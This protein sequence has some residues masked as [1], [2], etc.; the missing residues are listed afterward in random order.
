MPARQGLNR[1]ASVAACA[2]PAHEGTKP[3]HQPRKGPSTYW[4]SCQT[5]PAPR[6]FPIFA[7]TRTCC[8]D[9]KYFASRRLM[10]CRV[11]VSLRFRCAAS[12]VRF[13]TGGQGQGT[14][15]S[16]GGRGP[17]R[18]DM[19]L[20]LAR[21]RR[22]RTTFGGGGS[23]GIGSSY[24]VF[25]KRPKQSP[26]LTSRRN[27]RSGTYRASPGTIKEK[28]RSAFSGASFVSVEKIHTSETHPGS[29]PP[30]PEGGV[31]YTLARK[32]PRL[33]QESTSD[34]QR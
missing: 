22:S 28:R 7:Y 17:G 33:V 34:I 9:N 19:E 31:R 16:P 6:K 21:R 14:R 20:G 23:G 10:W 12:R 15:P 30:T 13:L 24:R 1:G 27:R 32:E 26:L 29:G 4:L 8:E 2:R 3:R 5:G 25:E 18:R 11:Q